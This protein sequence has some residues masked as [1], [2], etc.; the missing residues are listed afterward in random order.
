MD[1]QLNS[2]ENQI[3]YYSELIESKPNWTFVSGYADEGISG[4]T[5]KRREAFLQ[6][7]EDAKRGQFDFILTKEI[8]RFSRSTLDSIL[9]TQELLAHNVGVLF[10]NDNINTLEPDSEFRLTVMAGVAQDESRKLSDRLKFGFKQAIKNGHVLGNDRLYGY[11]K[12]GCVLTIKEDE[13]ELVR[14]VFDLYANRGYG[15]RRVSLELLK[16]GYTSRMGNAFNTLTIRNMLTNPKYKGWYCGNKSQNINYRTKEKV[17]LDESEWVTYPDPSI[18]AIVSEELWDR[19]NKL[20]R[21]RRE[22]VISH[23]SGASYHNR[24]PYSGKVYCEIHGSPYYRQAV[25]NK[26]GTYEV[27]RC[28]AYHK[29]GTGGCAS[30]QIR[31]SDLDELLAKHFKE[32]LLNKAIV[33][34]YLLGIL[35]SYTTPV[36]Y[37]GEKHRLEGELAKIHAKKEH[38]L[39]LSM[40]GALSNAEFKSR[41][42][43]YNG[44]LTSLQMQLEARSSYADQAEARTLDTGTI[45]KT[46]V[47]ELSF[48]KGIKSSLV[49]CLLEKAVV[50]MDSTK[51][52]IHLDLQL[53]TGFRFQ[54]TVTRAS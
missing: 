38:L 21:E 2:L 54:A 16:L 48:S 43:E 12:Q 19:A 37:D 18:P 9:Y 27:W 29:H 14:T 42:D 6:M 4:T 11:S 17:F 3:Q 1:A 44:R 15:T 25:H 20:Y 31:S 13:A 47:S 33:A 39:E 50:K 5:T 26:C 24:Y 52:S 7:I 35:Q 10:Q 23:S 34:D 32:Q 36:T 28:R 45:R 40:A 22:Y 41:N 46:I 51:E 49:A 8:S 53:V 30:P